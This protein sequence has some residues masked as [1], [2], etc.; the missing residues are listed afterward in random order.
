MQHGKGT[1]LFALYIACAAAFVWLTSS[2]LPPLVASHF[3][4]GGV[5]NGFMTRT[6][7]TRFMEAFVIGLPA[8]MVL[9]SLYAVGN[10]RARLNM[11]NRDYWLAPERR[12]TIGLPADRYSVVWCPAGD[13]FV[14]RARAGG[15]GQRGSASR[16]LGVLVHR[17]PGDLLP[18]PVRRAQ[19]ISAPLSAQ[20]LNSTV[21][22]C[23]FSIGGSV[24]RG[25]SCEGSSRAR[26]L[27]RN[28]SSLLSA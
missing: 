5:A 14:L 28:D 7:Y 4:A 22:K 25:A 13:L 20:P 18:G 12:A 11:P 16:A 1:G 26:F 15:I 2:G 23:H 9:V 19:G 8:F 6:V 17:R 24:P 10:A 27:R 3:G 21:P